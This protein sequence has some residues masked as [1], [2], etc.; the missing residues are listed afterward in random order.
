MKLLRKISIFS[1]VLIFLIAV[2]S[3]SIELINVKP[4]KSFS[5]DEDEFVSDAI[6]VGDKLYV[7]ESRKGA[8]K[9]FENYKYIK[10]ISI[11]ELDGSIGITF[12]KD[13]YYIS[14]PNRNKVLIYNSSFKKIKDVKIEDPTDVECYRDS[15]FVI[16]NNGH[17]IIKTDL[18]FSK[19]RLESGKFGYNKNEFR[20]PFDMAIDA[21]GD[22]FISEVIN[23]RVQIVN[24]DLKFVDY[25]GDWGVDKG[26]F[27]RP[28]GV[29][30]SNKMLAVSDGFIGVIQL[31][32]IDKKRFMGVFSTDNK[33]LRFE[34]PTR[35]RISNNKLIVVDYY[36]KKIH[37]YRFN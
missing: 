17:K 27:Y 4:I 25:L 32:D 9:I 35:I 13:L 5:F 34:S 10:T 1:L 19:N 28:K 2:K 29:A 30:I 6:F 22:I 20:F 3:Y 8:I 7:L 14:V 24:N 33:I 12:Y 18:L 15:C 31:F 16:S 37:I 36:A 26:Q 21:N 11:S 23:T